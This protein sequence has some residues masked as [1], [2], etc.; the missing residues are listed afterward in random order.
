MIGDTIYDVRCA[1]SINAGSIAYKAGRIG[2]EKI[3]AQEGADLI[4]G[5]LDDIKIIDYIKK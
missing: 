4:I 2:A 5:S 3:L 1:K